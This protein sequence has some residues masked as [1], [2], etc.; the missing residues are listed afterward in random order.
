MRLDEL[1]RPH[2]ASAS[3][4]TWPVGLCGVVSDTSFVRGVM[5]AATRSGS[6]AQPSS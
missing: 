4:M 1:G 6:T 5:S 2:A 3:D